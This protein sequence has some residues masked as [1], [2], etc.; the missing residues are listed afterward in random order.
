[1][2]GE[3]IGIVLKYQLQRSRYSME[4]RISI[5]L[6]EK[7]LWRGLMEKETDNK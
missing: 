3:P 4:E 5:R 1:M 7:E 6:Q 2:F